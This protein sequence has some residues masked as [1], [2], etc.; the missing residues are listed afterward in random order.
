MTIEDLQSICKKL[1]GV[2]QD[3]KWED[4]LC[5]NVGGKM[6][7]ITSPD[8][9]PHSASFKV[10]DEDFADLTSREGFIPAPY[11]S[12][13]KWIYVDDINRLT[14]RQW[15]LYAVKSFHLIA[16]KLALKTKKSIGLQ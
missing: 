11:L 14:K 5:F 7:L 16:A 4:H 3:I 13:Y 15:E 8:S 2:T 10:T 12:M 1:K 9:L 6:F